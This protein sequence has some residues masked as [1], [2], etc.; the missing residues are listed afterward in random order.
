MER[1]PLEPFPFSELAINEIFTYRGERWI[2]WSPHNAKRWDTNLGRSVGSV[3]RF[4]PDTVVY[5]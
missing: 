3:V 5:L 1:E 4:Q 2:K